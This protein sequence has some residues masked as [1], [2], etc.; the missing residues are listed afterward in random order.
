MR[1]P[2]SRDG[3]VNELGAFWFASVLGMIGVVVPLLAIDV[4]HSPAVVGLLVATSGVA[5]LLA[6]LRLAAVLRRL[7]DKVFVVIAGM[8]VAAACVLLAL[9][10]HLAAFIAAQALVGSARA[11]YWTGAQ[12]HAVRT[13]RRS[14]GALARLNLFAGIGALIGPF[15]AGVLFELDPLISLYAAA[16]TGL[17][18]ASVGLLLAKLPVFAA[19]SPSADGRLWRRSSVRPGLAMTTISGAWRG[20]LDSFVPVVLTLSGQSAVAVGAV[21][22]VAHVAAL[23]GGSAVGLLRDLRARGSLIIGGLVTAAGMACVSPLAGEPVAVAA[24]LA[25]AGLAAGA[26]QTIGTAA[27]ADGVPDEERGDAIATSGVFRA[28]A[29]LVSPLLSAGVLAVA[30]VP[31]AFV[32]LGGSLALPVFSAWARHPPRSSTE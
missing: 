23:I 10:T 16:T 21:I 17:V 6:R 32:L 26:L 8:L 13:G 25:G 11:Y 24:V 18:T 29:L 20:L 2:R 14:V 12:T 5:Q 3:F 31:V 30:P 4:G 28:G 15:A 1:S 19:P 9:S 27:V 22:A 7:P